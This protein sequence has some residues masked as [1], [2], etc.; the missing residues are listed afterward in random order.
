MEAVGS[1][2][3]IAQLA[4]MCLQAGKLANDLVK[5]FFQAPAQIS[6]LSFK[7]K[8][9]QLLITE[10]ETAVVQ[11]PEPE[12]QVL[13]LPEHRAFLF[14][15]LKRALDSLERIKSIN[16]SQSA[17]SIRNRLQWATLDKRRAQRFLHEAQSAE[18]ELDILLHIISIRISSM[19]HHSLV[20]LSAGQASIQ[21]KMQPSFDN[22]KSWF[23][24]EIQQLA[25]QST[26]QPSFDDMKGWVSREI[27]HLSTQSTMQNSFDDMKNM[28]SGEVRQLPTQSTMQHSFNDM[29]NRLLGEIQQL[30]VRFRS[31]SHVEPVRFQEVT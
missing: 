8:R 3:A 11:S 30:R 1:A 25:T 27:R 10:L 13:L 17:G 19:N 26:I 22:M 16:D 14:F 12:S 28:I 9:L 18:S 29:E 7:L 24:G 20:L 5:S 31:T 15:G 6:N 4:V 23:S 21:S 2:A